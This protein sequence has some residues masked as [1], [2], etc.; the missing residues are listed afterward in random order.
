MTPA[1]VARLR[2]ELPEL[3]RARRARFE[4]KLGLDAYSAGS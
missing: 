3:P 2:A 1:D 4:S